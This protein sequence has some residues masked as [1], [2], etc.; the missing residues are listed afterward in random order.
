M[1]SFVATIPGEIKGWKPA[2]NER[3]VWY[4]HMGYYGGF[5]GRHDDPSIKNKPMSLR[6]AITILLE[7]LG[8]PQYKPLDK[9]KSLEFIVMNPMHQGPNQGKVV[10]REDIVRIVKQRGRI[11]IS[12]RYVGDKDR[13]LDFDFGGIEALS[14][15]KSTGTYTQ[16]EEL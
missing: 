2:R 14:Y 7:R 10:K 13:N 6:A 15:A 11:Q 4:D 1:G 5:F 9:T 16:D 8:K 3:Y 12:A